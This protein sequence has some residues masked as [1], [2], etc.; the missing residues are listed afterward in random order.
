[1]NNLADYNYYDQLKPTFDKIFNLYSFAGLSESSYE[2]IVI[3]CLEDNHYDEDNLKSPIEFFKPKVIDAIHTFIKEKLA[4]GDITIIKNYIKETFPIK[5]TYNKALDSLDKLN[6][7]LSAVDYTLSPEEIMTLISDAEP[8]KESLTAIYNKDQKRIS[9]GDISEYDEETE[10]FLQAYCMQQGIL[11]DIDDED[12][13]KEFLEAQQDLLQIEGKGDGFEED[14]SYQEDKNY[15]P[16]SVKCFFKLAGSHPLLDKDK[17]YELLEKAHTGNKSAQ[18]LLIN[19]NLRLVISIAKKFR[20]RGLPLEDL[21]QEGT[22]GLMTAIERFDCSR[23][24]KF[25]TYAYYWIWQS[26]NRSVEDTGRNVRIPVHAQGEIRKINKVKEKFFDENK[27]EPNITEI[28]Q[29]VGISEKRV[30]DLLYA[31]LEPVS[32]N[33]KVNDD[34]DTELENFIVMDS[35]SEYDKIIEE[36]NAH[37]I[38]KILTEVGL[39][40]MQMEIMLLRYG[41]GQDSPLS[42]ETIAKRYGVSRQAINQHEKLAFRKIIKSSKIEQYA[43]YT[44]DPDKAIQTLRALREKVADPKYN[45]KK[46]LKRLQKEGEIN[47]R[48]SK[49]DLL[50]S[51][52]IT[53]EEFTKTLAPRLSPEE[54]SLLQQ[55]FT[56]GYGLVTEI[57]IPKDEYSKIYSTIIPKL[58]RWISKKDQAS[59]EN[60]SSNKKPVIASVPTETQQPDPII[61]KLA[62][63]DDQTLDDF[64]KDI[65]DECI[66]M[67]ERI[68]T[69]NKKLKQA[70]ELYDKFVRLQQIEADLDGKIA[71]KVGEYAQA[72]GKVYG[73]K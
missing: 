38:I 6:S 63:S 36:I 16:D 58:R 4:T 24:T 51:L 22:L 60:G 29:L 18:D 10:N 8:L 17:T 32:I 21:F 47:M 56:D 70:V 14:T 62:T 11:T 64:I 33:R 2:Q 34:S 44:D 25:S 26:I 31:S 59:I 9:K 7:F 43:Q 61:T 55:R 46:E 30:L 50:T 40:P 27:R 57:P 49:Q 1:M 39:T 42:L 54:F 23:E 41:V 66:A 48:K 12:I 52:N 19:S 65:S 68:E 72:K 73:K 69:K 35:D 45:H 3:S 5:T 28:A 15:I 13:E 20:G 53:E 37:E 67:E 71:T